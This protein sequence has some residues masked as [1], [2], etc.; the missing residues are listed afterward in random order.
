[1][2]LGWALWECVLSCSS[3]L[4]PTNPNEPQS[5]FKGKESENYQILEKKELLKGNEKKY[6]LETV[7]IW[8]VQTRQEIDKKTKSIPQFGEK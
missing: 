6:T 8:Q 4:L 2:S 7:P 5:N 1:M 3:F